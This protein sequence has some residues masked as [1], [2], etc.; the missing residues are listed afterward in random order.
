MSHK[1]GDL[2]SEETNKMLFNIIADRE[3]R[4]KKKR[5]GYNFISICFAAMKKSAN[6]KWSHK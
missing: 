2:N 5:G 4:K 1:T 3:K 6:I